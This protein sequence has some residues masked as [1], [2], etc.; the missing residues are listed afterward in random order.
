M[1]IVTILLL[2]V[3]TRRIE[4]YF[5][6]VNESV[7]KI[8][9]LYCTVDIRVFEYKISTN[10]NLFD[11]PFAEPPLPALNTVQRCVL[12]YNERCSKKTYLTFGYK[13]YT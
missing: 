10:R 4:Y 12:G 3:S 6:T 13:K 8:V 1:R 11:R 9:A 5:C 2:L 7:E